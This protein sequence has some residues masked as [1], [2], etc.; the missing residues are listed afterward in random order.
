MGANVNPASGGHLAVHHQAGTVEFVKLFPI[1]PVAHQIGIAKQ[2]ARG[3]VVSAKN[4]YRLSRLNEKSFVIFQSPQGLHNGMK[5]FPISRRLT[6]AAVNH[7]VF[8]FFRHFRVQVI[9]QHAQRGFLLPAF[10]GDFQTARRAKRAAAHGGV[11]QDGGA[12]RLTPAPH[13]IS[14]AM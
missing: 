4:G 13:L 8:G 14:G 2:N 11:I 3:I 1:I 5:A 6:G 7:Q 9:Q 12:H 10:A